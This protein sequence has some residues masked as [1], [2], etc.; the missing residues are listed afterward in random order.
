MKSDPVSSEQRTKFPRWTVS[1]DGRHINDD[2]FH[3]DGQLKVTGDFAEDSD[4]VRYAQAIADA[5][6]NAEIPSE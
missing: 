4:R 5:L 2:Q 1:T 3:W 6:N